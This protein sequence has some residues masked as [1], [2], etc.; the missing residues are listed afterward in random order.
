MALLSH[1]RQRKSFYYAG[2]INTGF[3]CWF[4]ADHNHWL[5]NPWWAIVLVV[6]GLA[7]LAIGFGLDARE[8]RRERPGA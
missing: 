1:R 7:G 5:D 6:V 8:R 4:I 3:A 2:L